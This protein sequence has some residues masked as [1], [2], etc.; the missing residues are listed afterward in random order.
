MTSVSMFQQN[1]GDDYWNGYKESRT[2]KYSEMPESLMALATL[3][4]CSAGQDYIA[5]SF[6]KYDPDNILVVTSVDLYKGEELIT[7]NTDHSLSGKFESL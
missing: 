2:H 5:Y 7:S 1:T 4:S 6:D 3:S